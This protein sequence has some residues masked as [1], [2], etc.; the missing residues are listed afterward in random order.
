MSTL[1][2]DL[3]F[4][5]RMLLKTRGTTLAALVAFALGLGGNMAMYSVAD[6]LLFNPLRLPHAERLV[7]LP[8]IVN[9]RTTDMSDISLADFRDIREQSHTLVQPSAVE[10]WTTNLTGAGDPIQVR[11]FKV[12]PTFFDTLQATPLYGRA[13]DAKLPQ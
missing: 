13:P 4:A 10:W 3:R 11:G 12:S 6:V 5:W 8:S 9:G 7:L 2:D 1:L